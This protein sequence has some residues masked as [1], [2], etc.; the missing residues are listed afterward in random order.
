MIQTSVSTHE[1][2]EFLQHR[3]ARLVRMQELVS[4]STGDPGQW[5]ELEEKFKTAHQQNPEL[6]VWMHINESPLPVGP[7][8]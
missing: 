3:G 6:A 2:T 4:A 1:T 8:R 5:R 7:G